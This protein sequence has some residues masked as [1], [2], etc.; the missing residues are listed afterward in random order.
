MAIILY[1]LSIQ[2]VSY[3][4]ESESQWRHNYF[5]IKILPEKKRKAVDTLN[6]MNDVANK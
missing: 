3:P 6:A 5:L 2:N 1:P 4:Y